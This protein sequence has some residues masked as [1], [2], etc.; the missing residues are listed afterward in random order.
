MASTAFV[1]FSAVAP[2]AAQSKA[3]GFDN[4]ERA[5]QFY[6][7]ASEAYGAGDYG[8]AAE[9]LERAFAHEQNL[10]YKYNQILAIQGLGD[11]QEALRLLDIYG[12]PLRLDGRFDDVDELKE[13]LEQALEA[14]R[15]SE[16]AHEA[17]QKEQELAIEPPPAEP[18][19][20][21]QGTNILG[22]SLIGAGTAALATGALFGSG[23]LIKD[24]TARLE[25]SRTAADEE[26]IYGSSEFNR[27]D[28]LATLHTHRIL[29]AAL[30]AG[31]VTAAGAGG[32]ILFL[33]S[34]QKRGAAG[35]SL[36]VAP[37][38]NPDMAGAF[39]R[40]RF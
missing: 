18:A 26:T 29:T 23:V 32:V 21:L 7:E 9:L 4:E 40:G 10:V 31:G 34:G 27:E 36:E 25:D 11:Y 3:A 30:V 5:A 35:A 6:Q 2:A 37:V 8:R 14:H 33:K 39:I 13:E 16:A 1:C 19:P 15:E 28:D 22:W 17:A 20:A 24:V 38:I 12:D